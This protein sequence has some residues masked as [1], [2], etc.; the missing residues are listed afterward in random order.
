VHKFSDV[1]P[2]FKKTRNYWR[3]CWRKFL[4]QA[5]QFLYQT[6]ENVRKMLF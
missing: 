3:N 5:G 1:A 4:V 6:N 2:I